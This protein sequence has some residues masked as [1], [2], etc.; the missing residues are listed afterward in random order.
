MGMWFFR[1]AAISQLCHHNYY[2]CSYTHLL[3][4]LI[5]LCF[6]NFPFKPEFL[7][8]GWP[9]IEWVTI[10]VILMVSGV[11]VLKFVSNNKSY[12]K[13]PKLWLSNAINLLKGIRRRQRNLMKYEFIFS[14]QVMYYNSSDLKEHVITNVNL[15]LNLSLVGKAL[16]SRL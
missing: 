3:S 9:P 2:T 4:L 14:T 12:P 15:H 6:L 13:C 10:K 1:T 5:V 16:L 8:I 11:S 7:K